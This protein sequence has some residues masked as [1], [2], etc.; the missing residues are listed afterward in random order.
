MKYMTSMP[1]KQTNSDGSSSKNMNDD[2]KNMPG[3][4][5]M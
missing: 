1:E 3:M 5:G 2:M 4:E